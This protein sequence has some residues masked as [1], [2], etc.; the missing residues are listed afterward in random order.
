LLGQLGSLLA[1]LGARSIGLECIHGTALARRHGRVRTGTQGHG[2]SVNSVAFS[3]DS[4]LVASASYDKTV[5]LW[6][7]ATGEC[8]QELKGH[9]YWA[10][11]V[12]FSHDSALV[13]SASYDKTVQLWRAATGECVQEVN[14]G[15]TLDHLSFEAGDFH[16]LT[17]V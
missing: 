12:A 3:H 13:A 16:L 11:S 9:G 2:D 8:V 15:V 7:A 5:R 14:V 4:A 17:D 10:N 6:R 1:R